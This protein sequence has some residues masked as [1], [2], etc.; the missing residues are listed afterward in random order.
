MRSSNVRP[1]QPDGSVWLGRDLHHDLASAPLLSNKDRQLSA[2]VSDN[3]PVQPLIWTD[4][5]GRETHPE[6]QK[7]ASQRP[8]YIASHR[9]GHWFDPSIA[10]AGQRSVRDLRTGPSSPV[11]QRSTATPGR[12]TPP[13]SPGG[14][15]AVLIVQ[16]H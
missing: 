1:R 15:A 5:G 7:P 2:K 4:V 9:R 6:L 12:G 13:V 8:A 11:Q 14:P 16:A 3:H 10:H